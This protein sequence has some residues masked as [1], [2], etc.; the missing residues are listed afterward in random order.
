MKRLGQLAGGRL[1]MKRLL[2]AAKDLKDMLPRR[3]TYLAFE[4]LALAAQPS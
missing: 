4:G 3:V 2:G 1:R